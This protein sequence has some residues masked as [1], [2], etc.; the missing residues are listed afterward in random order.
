MNLFLINVMLA[1]AWAIVNGSLTARD[2]AVGFFVGYLILWLVSPA[3][4]KTAYHERVLKIPGFAL[5]YLGELVRANVDV[6]IAV[7]SPRRIQHPGIVAVPLDCETDAEISAVANLVSLTPGSI[8]VS[9]SK[10]RR[11]LYV[12]VMDLDVE[13][14]ESFRQEVKK[15]IEQRVVT[16]IRGE[17]AA[18]ELLRRE[19]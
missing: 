4:G 13:Q 6:A 14:V 1:F 11:T 12:H 7:L 10:D 3:L 9:V 2:V 15:G 18:C 8:S 19:P 5:W 16:L 17:A